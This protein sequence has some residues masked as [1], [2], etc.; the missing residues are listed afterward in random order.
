MKKNF[1]QGWYFKCSTDWETVA[2]IVALHHD[3]RQ[4]SASLQVI[5]GTGSYFF[6]YPDIRYDRYSNVIRIGPNTFSLKGIALHIE[7]ADL[8]ISGFLKFSNRQRIAYDIMGPFRY[9]PLMQCR[10]KIYSMTHQ[11]TGRLNIGGQACHF[12]GH[13]GYIEGDRGTSFPKEYVWT[14]CHFP[15]G[16]LTLAVA[17]IPFGCFHFTGVIGVVL[18]DGKEYRIATYLGAKVQ[19]IGSHIIWIRQGDYHLTAKLLQKKDF[20]LHAPQKG[21]MT[22]SIRE[23]P[24]CSAQYHFYCNDQDILRFQSDMASFEYEYPR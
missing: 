13:P 1:F 18:I 20:P 4:K 9:V 2:F 8:S 7:S 12:A 5:N 10:H 14:H 17:H 11:V 15:G 24:M 6:S 3:G 22:R 21:T 16:A 19:H 23:S